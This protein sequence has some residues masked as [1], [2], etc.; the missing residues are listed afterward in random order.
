MVQICPICGGGGHV[1]E[2]QVDGNTYMNVIKTCHGCGGKG[3]IETQ[4]YQEPCPPVSP[5]YPWT[6]YPHYPYVTWTI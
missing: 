6:P 2:S 1:Y 4:G 5:M 3:W